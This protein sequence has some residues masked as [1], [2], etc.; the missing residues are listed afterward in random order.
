MY[1]IITNLLTNSTKSLW[2][3]STNQSRCQCKCQSKCPCHYRC[4]V[5][6]ILSWRLLPQ[7][8]SKGF[9][10]IWFLPTI[11]F[12]TTNRNQ[13]EPYLIPKRNIIAVWW[14]FIILEW[15][16]QSNSS[17]QGKRWSKPSLVTDVKF[18]KLLMLNI[19]KGI[20]QIARDW[21]QKELNWIVEFVNLVQ[22]IQLNSIVIFERSI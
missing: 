6:Q 16:N 19:L 18:M 2:M 12:L 10:R 13:L 11:V 7:K 14:S 21:T 3:R 17:H 9:I 15:L 1:K 8:C 20:F 5:I 4:T 22:Q